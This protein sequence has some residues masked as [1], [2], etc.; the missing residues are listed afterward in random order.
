M[1]DPHELAK[2]IAKLNGN[3]VFL[4]ADE[5]RMI[6]AALLL[7]KAVSDWSEADACSSVYHR[8][9]LGP[10]SM[11]EAEDKKDRALNA[12]RAARDGAR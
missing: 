8:D 4:A 5:C 7:A 3:V 10:C 6:A 11:C 9:G 2:A 12:Y 1:T